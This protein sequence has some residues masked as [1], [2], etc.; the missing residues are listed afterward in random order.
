M[1]VER[2]KEILSNLLSAQIDLNEM[3]QAENNEMAA[4]QK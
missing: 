2:S 4:N 1:D 3:L